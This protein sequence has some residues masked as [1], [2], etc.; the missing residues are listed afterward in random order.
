MCFDNFSLLRCDSNKYSVDY[1][2]SLGKLKEKRKLQTVGS[3]SDSDSGSDEE[4]M[5][6]DESEDNEEDFKI[7]KT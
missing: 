1:I 2:L 4:P 6:V 7:I 3:Q 5:G